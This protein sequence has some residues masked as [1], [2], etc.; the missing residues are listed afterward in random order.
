MLKNTLDRVLGEDS[1]VRSCPI[2]VYDNH[3][4][5]GTPALLAEYARRY[6][7]LKAVSNRRNIGLSGNICK[8][9][10]NA[11]QNISGFSATMT[12]LTGP[13]GRMY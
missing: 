1:P 12:P 3:S 5:D 8:A 13:T 7:N 11:S 6:P 9:L 10:E 2:V 4:T